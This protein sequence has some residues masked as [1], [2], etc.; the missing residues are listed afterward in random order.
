MSD[1]TSHK[2]IFP[3]SI[4]NKGEHILW[5]QEAGLSYV[6]CVVRGILPMIVLIVLMGVFGSLGQTLGPGALAF[7]MIF[8]WIGLIGL[9]VL[10]V[11]LL[12]LI[13]QPRRIQ[14]VLTND[15]LVEARGET[16]MKEI[17]RVNLKDLDSEQFLKQSL[18]HKQPGREYFNYQIT[19]PVSGVVILMTALRDDIPEM[20]KKW[21]SKGKIY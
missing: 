13:I 10:F 1:D 19:D 20:L 16:I 6:I 15:R 18:S 12:L 3:Y 2:E 8:T 14:Y 4:L 21:V 17:P 5:N 11:Y 9:I 7:S